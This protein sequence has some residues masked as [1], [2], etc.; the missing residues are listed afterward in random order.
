[1]KNNRIFCL[2]IILLT[3]L[4][5]SNSFETSFHHDDLH[6]IVRNPFVKDFNKIPQFF[7]QPQ[8]GSG[9]Y[10][11]TSSYRPLLMASFA[12]NYYL[13]GLNVFG[14]HLFN[15]GLHV[16][17][18]LLVYFIALYIFRFTGTP[19]EVQPLRYQ[20]TALFSALVFTLHPVQ[21]ES[22]TYVTGRSSLLTAVFFLASFFTYLQFGLTRRARYLVISL[23]SYAGALLAKETAVTIVALLILFDFLFPHGRSWKSRVLSLLPY[24]LVSC[25]Y[26]G[27]RIYFFGFF[28]YAVDP[29]RPF[30]SHIFSQSRA[31][32]HY[33]G[34]LLLPLNLNIDY[35]FPL[36]HSILEGEVILSLFL[37]AG[38]ALAIAWRS[39]SNRLIGFWAG[40]FAINLLPTNSV[41]IL[42]DLVSDRWLY[43]SSVGYAVLLAYAISWI[44]QTLVAR[45]ARAARILFFFLCALGIELYGFSTLLRN[46]T[47]NND[48]SLWE[49]AVAKSPHKARPHDALGVALASEGRLQEAEQSLKRAIHLAPRGG[50]AYIN[51]GY[52][53]S[54][55]GKSEEALAAYEMAIPL[56]PRLL[57]EIYN[58]MGLIYF[59]QERMEEAEKAFRK[60]IEIRPH[61]AP[62]YCNL[63]AYYEK[64][65]DI[66]RAIHYYEIT[67][68]LAPDYHLA[69][70][71]LSVLYEQKGWKEKSREAY[72]KFLSGALR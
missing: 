1:M 19:S 15:F 46:F 37:L 5:Y 28:Q 9:I 55:Q 49:D 63:G 29:V 68:K 25:M 21:T 65:G 6:V 54:L 35:D 43:L 50:Q 22:V 7:F 60:S 59:R 52:V 26:M 39:P 8:M 31:W 11:E 36:S 20:L 64:K 40:W 10:S 17:C 4:A 57:S 3:L 66:D 32:V 70:G 47:W 38:L 56:C 62:P 13:G 61:H 44:Y 71:A 2:I 34:T 42:E 41:I 24:F 58:N 30:P 18:G 53:Y 67:V 33:L 14:Y 12:L 72:Q 48:R 16:A 45:R 27:I 51:L 23:L 69:Y